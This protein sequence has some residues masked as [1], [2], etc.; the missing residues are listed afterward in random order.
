MDKKNVNELFNK[1]SDEEK[2][3]VESILADKQKTEE[4]MKTPQ[5]QA[6]LKKL[7]WER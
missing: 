2:K 4:I 3:K 1:L 7:M 6:Q 5:A